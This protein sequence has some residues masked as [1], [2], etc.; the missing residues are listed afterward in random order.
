MSVYRVF[1]V[2]WVRIAYSSAQPETGT[3]TVGLTYLVVTIE[4][5]RTK[6]NYQLSNYTTRVQKKKLYALL[7]FRFNG[8][9]FWRS[10]T[11]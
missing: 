10:Y 6:W 3:E 8:I 5:K 9:A 1:H 4:Q 7:V 11:S 2:H